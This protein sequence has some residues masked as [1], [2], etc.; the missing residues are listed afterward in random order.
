MSEGK[1]ERR[2]E[3]L[4]ALWNR[5]DQLL[6]EGKRGDD[7]YVDFFCAA[8]NLKVDDDVDHFNPVEWVEEDTHAWRIWW[9]RALRRLRGW[10]VR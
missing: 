4:E 7:V 2:W 9:R 8:W 6:T 1:A 5:V 10:E 3:R